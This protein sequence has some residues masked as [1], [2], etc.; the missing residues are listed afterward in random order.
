MKSSIVVTITLARLKKLRACADG[1]DN[2][3]A[4]FESLRK[5]QGR[6]RSVRIVWDVLGQLWLAT[7]YPSHSN[8][9][10]E[11]GLIPKID[12]YGAN[13]RGADLGGADLGGA[14][15]GGADLRGADLGGADLGGA[16]LRGALNLAL[17]QQL[18][19]PEVGAF[20]AWKKLDGDVVAQLEIPAKAARVGGVIGR[21]CRAEFA[22]VVALFR[23]GKKLRKVASNRFPSMHDAAF[24]YEAGKTV[25]PDSWDPSPLVECAPGIHFF[26]NKQEALEYQ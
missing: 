20:T 18:I 17:H 10:Y 15:L 2:G 26:I 14:D 8:W 4:L 1:P 6:K 24:Y 23:E 21:K 25:R 5:M 11:N 13:L 12:L 22:V 16:D 9:L 3:M 19:V 7:A